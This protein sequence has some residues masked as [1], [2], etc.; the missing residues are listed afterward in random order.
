MMITAEIV[1]AMRA[2]VNGQ[3]RQFFLALLPTERDLLS[4]GRDHPYWDQWERMVEHLCGQVGD[5]INLAEEMKDL[6]PDALDKG[7]DGTHFGP[8]TNAIISSILKDYL[9]LNM[10]QN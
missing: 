9:L 10:T 4:K 6:P 2:D 5:C 7:Y 1:R 3:N 8:K